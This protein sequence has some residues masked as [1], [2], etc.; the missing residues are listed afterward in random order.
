MVVT[1]NITFVSVF[2]VENIPFF[3]HPIVLQNKTKDFQV[4]GIKKGTKYTENMDALDINK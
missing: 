2:T 4:H 1:L 3:P